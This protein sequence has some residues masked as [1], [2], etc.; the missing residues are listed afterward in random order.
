MLTVAPLLGLYFIYTKH[1]KTPNIT[2]SIITIS[3]SISNINKISNCSICSI[4]LCVLMIVYP[5]VIIQYNA[6]QRNLAHID[7]IL[8]MCMVINQVI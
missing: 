8:I 1:N 2:P 7:F 4:S 6:I 5:Q 3:M